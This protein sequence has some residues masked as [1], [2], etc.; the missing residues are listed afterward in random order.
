MITY[1][2]EQAAKV[3]N[4]DIHKIT[5]LRKHGLLHGIK[6]G[7]R[8]WIYSEQDLQNFWNEYRDEDLSNSER[9]KVISEIHSPQKK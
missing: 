5:A 1:T 2:A 8:G 6:L 9:I 4:C 7:K 3:M